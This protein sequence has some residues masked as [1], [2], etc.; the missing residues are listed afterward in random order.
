M[1]G[2]VAELVTKR[3]TEK[4][5]AEQRPQKI[6]EMEQSAYTILEKNIGE[7]K[8]ILSTLAKKDEHQKRQNWRS[9]D[10]RHISSIGRHLDFAIRDLEMRVGKREYTDLHGNPKSA[11]DK[12]ELYEGRNSDQDNFRGSLKLCMEAINIAVMNREEGRNVSLG[13][14]DDEV[15][16]LK[17]LRSKLEPTIKFI[18]GEQQKH[19]FTVADYT[20]LALKIRNDARLES[21]ERAKPPT[22]DKLKAFT[23][24][25]GGKIARLSQMIRKI[26]AHADKLSSD[27][28]NPS[29]SKNNN[30][31]FTQVADTLDTM[32]RAIASLGE[33]LPLSENQ[34]SSLQNHHY[35]K[36]IY[37]DDRINPAILDSPNKE[38]TPPRASIEL[39]L[40][41][42]L[43][44]ANRAEREHLM[45]EDFLHAAELALSWASYSQSTDPNI[46][47]LVT[48]C[49]QA[50]PLVREVREAFK[51]AN[52]S[53]K[54]LDLLLL[55]NKYPEPARV[56]VPII[57]DPKESRI[58]TPGS[59]QDHGS[60]LVLTPAQ[61]S[62]AQRELYLP[63]ELDASRPPSDW[64]TRTAKPKGSRHL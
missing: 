38:G 32:N 16:M 12:A 4:L 48:E 44:P 7:I 25:N 21:E 54:T 51:A 30:A 47:T 17:T 22:K 41:S 39:K 64:A 18:E 58:I 56:G 55:E 5:E 49:K 28:T 60:R 33:G 20:A 19:T 50:Q 45:G 53:P 35:I 26:V 1:P 11:T 13:F 6:L 29:F 10:N 8:L 57:L 40:L 46:R 3:N 27:P 61:L 52:I 34:A 24:A 9:E 59:T 14:A 2:V 43:H 37:F 31:V 63:P 23:A 15:E 36:R 62:P 42:Q